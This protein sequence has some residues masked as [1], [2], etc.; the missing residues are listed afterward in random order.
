VAGIIF[1][2]LVNN[3]QIADV[4]RRLYLDMQD[5]PMAYYYAKQAVN[6]KPEHIPYKL[7]FAQILYH[8]KRNDE[9]IAQLQSVL[10][11]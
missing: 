9:A 3:A 8:L 6:L 4:A 5:M 10:T 1:D 2:A 7:N 11:V